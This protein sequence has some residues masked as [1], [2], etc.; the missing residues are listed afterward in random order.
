MR[1]GYVLALFAAALVGA[2]TLI[3]EGNMAASFTACI[4]CFLIGFGLARL[5]EEDFA[6]KGSVAPPE[7]DDIESRVRRSQS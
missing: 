4:V 2:G 5:E 1:R 7:P 6:K 3:L